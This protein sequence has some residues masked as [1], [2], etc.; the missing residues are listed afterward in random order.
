MKNS[1]ISTMTEAGIAHYGGGKSPYDIIRAAKN[2]APMGSAFRRELET[3]LKQDK[4]YLEK[5]FGYL[6]GIV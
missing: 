2:K 5:A 6:G 4:V 1:L 3:V